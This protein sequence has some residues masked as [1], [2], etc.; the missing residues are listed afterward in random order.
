[1]GRGGPRGRARRKGQGPWGGSKA[2]PLRVPWV[3]QSC[4][5]SRGVVRVSQYKEDQEARDRRNFEA[6]LEI[7]KEAW[8]LKRERLGLP[9]GDTD[10]DMDDISSG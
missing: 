10:P 7:K 4:H 9:P 6:M 2:L 3:R 1:M 8:R 5:A